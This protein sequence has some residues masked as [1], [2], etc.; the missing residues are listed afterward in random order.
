MCGDGVLISRGHKTKVFG[1]TGNHVPVVHVTPAATQHSFVAS[2]MEIHA[3]FDF[4]HGTDNLY[5]PTRGWKDTDAVAS[6]TFCRHGGAD[7]FDVVV[8]HRNVWSAEILKSHTRRHEIEGLPRTNATRI[9]T[10]SS[11]RYDRVCNRP[12]KL[13]GNKT[14]VFTGRKVLCRVINRCPVAPY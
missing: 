4:G 6:S 1:N 13:D 10:P 9:R 5:R 12:G 14:A 7:H 2:D 11:E 3:E 8:N